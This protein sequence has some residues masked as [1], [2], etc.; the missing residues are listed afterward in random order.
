MLENDGYYEKTHK[1]ACTAQNS[2]KTMANTLNDAKQECNIDKDCKGIL[3]GS[4]DNKIYFLCKKFSTDYPSRIGCFHLKG[5]HYF[6]HSKSFN[7][8]Y[9]AFNDY[10][11]I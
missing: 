2:Q 7:S 10:L 9:I 11:S 1:I 5:R 8:G 3:D 4:C 6:Y